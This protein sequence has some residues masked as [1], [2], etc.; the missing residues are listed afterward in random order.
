MRY[1]AEYGI[2]YKQTMVKMW[3]VYIYYFTAKLC[4]HHTFLVLMSQFY[5][6]TCCMSAL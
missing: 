3:H 4:I 2:K 1:S 5:L 6:H